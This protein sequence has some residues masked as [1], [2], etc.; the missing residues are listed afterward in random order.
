MYEIK[1]NLNGKIY[2]G[3]H[4][5]KSMDDGYMGSGTII[6]HA[7]EK[8]GKDNFTK[9]IL[10]EFCSA[11]EMYAREKEVVNNEFLLRNDTYNLNRGGHGGF[12]FIHSQGIKSML[13]RHVSEETKE[14]LRKALTGHSVSDESRKKMSEWQLGKPKPATTLAR[15]GK[16]LS[17]EHKKNLSASLKGKPRESC[18]KNRKSRFIEFKMVICPY[19]NKEGK[20]NAMNR[21]HFDNCPNK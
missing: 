2:I 18:P 3:V 20:I 12:D 4:K 11:E 10:E 6:R 1:N 8:Y 17:D 16:H 19:C 7:I 15:K 14:K 5:T 9:T 21:W 13:G